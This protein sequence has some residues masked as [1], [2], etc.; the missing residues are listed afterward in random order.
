MCGIGAIS[1]R[2]PHPEA[3]ELMRS[4]AVANVERGHH[5]SGYGWL[6]LDDQW[7]WT[8]NAE[9]SALD[10]HADAPLVVTHTA[11]VHT[12]WAT[13]G[14]TSDPRNN[15]PV[16]S[17]GI[18]LVHNGTLSNDD[19]LFDRYPHVERQAEVDSEAIAA[20]LSGDDRHPADVLEQVRGRMAVAWLDTI[21]GDLHLARG[22]GSPMV[23]AQN[24]RGDF[25]MASTEPILR[26]ALKWEP[27]FGKLEWV[28]TVPEGT[29]LRVARG[30]V[31]EWRRFKVQQTYV[32][33]RLAA[34]TEGRA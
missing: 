30:R 2:Q 28:Q 31:A 10:T 22:Q 15:H 8:W 25:V 7:P 9:G 20:I 27:W 13:K 29:Y 32:S 17:P 14:D 21:S 16:T 19:D 11:I 3:P 24:H 23:V 33:R 34:M 1:L 26:A 5:A 12:R 18:V 4:L 6:D